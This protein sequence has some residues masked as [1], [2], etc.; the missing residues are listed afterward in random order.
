MAAAFSL[1]AAYVVVGSVNQSCLEADLSKDAKALLAQCRIG[2][3]VMAPSADMFELGVKVQVLRRGTMFAVHAERLYALYRAHDGLESLDAATRAQLQDRIFRADVEEVWQRTRAFFSERNPEEVRRAERDPK[4]RM[5]LVFRWYLGLSSQWPIAGDS[6]RR[7][8]YQI[9][10]GPAM[11]AFN[12][13]VAGSFLEPLEARSV[14][15]V[16]RNLLEGAA[17]VTRA[18]QLRSAGVAVPRRAFE[19]RPRPLG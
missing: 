10:C 6:D 19:F 17:C 18:Q 11:G 14:A 3:T 1:G 8:D 15:Q 7:V 16:A 4:H 5:A 12:A 2:D 13:W 9:W